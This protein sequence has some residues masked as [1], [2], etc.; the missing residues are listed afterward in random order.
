MENRIRDFRRGDVFLANLGEHDLGVNENHLQT[1]RRPIVIVQNNIG[2]HFAETVTMVPLTASLK[3]LRQPTHYVLQDA[4][5]LKKQSM[6]VAEQVA[7]INKHQVLG[8]LGRL[9]QTDMKGVDAALMT[10]LGFPIPECID[11]P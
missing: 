4:S 9:S 2:C 5:F 3:K 7:T 6:V 11:P 8:Y 1:G 10:Q